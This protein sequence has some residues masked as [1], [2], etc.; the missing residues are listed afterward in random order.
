MTPA[1]CLP[2]CLTSS[3]GFYPSLFL[4]Q[5]PILQIH[6]HLPGLIIPSVL[7]I[8]PCA[9]SSCHFLPQSAAFFKTHFRTYLGRYASLHPPR[10]LITPCLVSVALCELCLIVF[11]QLLR[12]KFLPHQTE[13]LLLMLNDPLMLTG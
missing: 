13:P 3:L 6:L 12:H 1:P 4:F 2:A 11:L 10:K 7:Q 8:I 9:R 5:R